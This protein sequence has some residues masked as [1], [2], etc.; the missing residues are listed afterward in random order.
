MHDNTHLYNIKYIV[1]I[2]DSIFDRHNF[3]NLEYD[4][5]NLFSCLGY[6]NCTIRCKN[7]YLL[8]CQ[9]RGCRKPFY[10]HRKVLIGICFVVYTKIAHISTAFC[11]Q[12][13]SRAARASESGGLGGSRVADHIPAQDFLNNLHNY[14]Q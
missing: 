8:G 4:F 3:V 6:Q 1:Y 7:M 13:R 2:S 5:Y 14:K 10:Y 12:Q 11:R 9:I